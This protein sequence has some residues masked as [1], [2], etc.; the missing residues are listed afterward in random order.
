MARKT[1]L[2][3]AAAL[4]GAVLAGGAAWA[5]SAPS[6]ETADARI[7][8]Q[9]EHKLS[10]DFPNSADRMRVS[11]QDGVVTLSGFADSGLAELQAIKDA[12]AVPGVMHVKD[13]L[14]VVA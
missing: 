3:M 8:Q 1:V 10:R 4:G 13:Q 14:Q 9:V 11:T 7:T 6:G 5:A 12:R 2:A